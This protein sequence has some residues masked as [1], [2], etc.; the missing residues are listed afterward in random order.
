MAAEGC[1][2]NERKL[3]KKYETIREE[4]RSGKKNWAVV[5]PKCNPI[6]F[7]DCEKKS[8]R[9]VKKLFVFKVGVT[10]IAF[11]W[12]AGSRKVPLF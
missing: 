4:K 3:V 11:L 7:V 10:L 9:G 1:K 2:K 5:L 8:K 12:L 6:R